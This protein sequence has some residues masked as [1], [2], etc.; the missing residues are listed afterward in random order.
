L[1][2]PLVWVRFL[3]FAATISLS[4]LVIF[5]SLVSAPALAAGGADTA[6]VRLI[7]GR[8]ARL[9]WGSLALA[10][11]SGVALLMV[12]TASMGERPLSALWSDD[13]VATVLLDTDYGHV[14]L[15][16]LALVVLLAA[17]LRPPYFG[18]PAPVWR[19]TVALTLAIGFVAALAFAGHAA[20]GEGAEGLIHEAADVLHLVA[21]AAWVG[22][23]VPLAMVLV[24]ANLDGGPSA[25]A[26]ARAATLRFSTLGI[27]SVGTVLATG[28]VNTW[29]LAGSAAALFDTAYGRLLLAKIALF[30][31]M[32]AI[33]AV[34]RMR[35]T[36][37]LVVGGAAAGPAL[38]RLRT[39]A[40]IEAVIGALILFIV[41]ELGTLP[42]GR[43]GVDSTV[44]ASAWARRYA[45]L[46][47]LRLSELISAGHASLCPPYN[48]RARL[49]MRPERSAPHLGKS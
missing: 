37:R 41:A 32:L 6:T 11:V 33:A 10:A 23:L 30:L 28:I 34:N 29:E 25:F 12:Q 2:D 36:P 39:N 8:L 13:L 9:A 24:V 35:L 21:A 31:V 18:A 16:R 26:V 14:S 44:A 27:A 46:P 48:F 1:S 49:G 20:A 5:H 40:L 43:E 38:R 3:H 17:G 45:P 22:A 4:G 7:A 15:V 47:I 42:P 19:R